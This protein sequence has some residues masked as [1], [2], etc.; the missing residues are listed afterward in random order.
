MANTSDNFP[1]LSTRSTEKEG[2]WKKENEEGKEDEE[3]RR[4]EE[5]EEGEEGGREERKQRHT[6]DSQ[7]ANVS[8]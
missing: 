5:G 2:R 6:C 7:V 3:G 1:N 8:K 4:E